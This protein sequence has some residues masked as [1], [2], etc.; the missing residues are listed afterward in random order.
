MAISTCECQS[1]RL[2]LKRKIHTGLSV[3]CL[4][5]ANELAL[6]QGWQAAAVAMKKSAYSNLGNSVAE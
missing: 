1:V 6:G 3:C 5:T 2:I 4:R